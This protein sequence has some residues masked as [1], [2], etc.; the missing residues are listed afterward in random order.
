MSWKH[1]TASKDEAVYHASRTE[2]WLWQRATQLGVSRRR[3][4]QALS[5]GGMATLG[6]RMSWGQ[7]PAAPAAAPEELIR[8][9]TPPELF[10]DYGS[11]KEMRWESLYGR[12]Y[13]VPNALFFVRNHTRTPRLDAAT[14]RL[15]VTG[16]GITRPLELTYDDLLAMPAH[17]VI[18]ALECA[19]NG[20]SLFA[21]AYG[22]KAQGT[23]WKL[24][25]IGLAEWTGE[26]DGKDQ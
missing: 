22:K 20:R 3:L 8:K 26:A 19:G 7:T 5:V 24:G 2:A 13:L 17:S 12:G 11:N 4:F 23:Q 21:T 15:T 25:A 6:S 10:F 1:D 14:W 9:P 16:S 18:R